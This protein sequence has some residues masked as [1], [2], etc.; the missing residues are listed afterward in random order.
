MANKIGFMEM[1]TEKAFECMAKLVPY[2]TEIERDAEV[3]EAKKR[4]TDPNNTETRNSDVMEAVLPLMLQKHREAVF[5][6]VGI[7]MDKTAEE[8]SKQ[9]WKVTLGVLKS[10][11][12]NDLYDF[13]P[14]AVQLVAHA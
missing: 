4:L 9:P 7:V 6:I 5:A 8:V 2:V 14:F 11:A 3:I 13:F 10:G 1:D 12:M